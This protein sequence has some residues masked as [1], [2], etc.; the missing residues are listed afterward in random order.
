MFVQQQRLS[1]APV[2][3]VQY[4]ARIREAGLAA[5]LRIGSWVGQD[6]PVPLQAVAKLMPEVMISRRFTNVADGTT[7]GFLLEYCPDAHD[8]AGHFPPHCFP[9][10]GWSPR[11][12]RARDWAVEGLKIEGMEYT[13]SF[14][15]E[16]GE[17]ERTEVVMNCMLRP[18][19]VLRD[20]DALARANLLGGGESV[21]AGQL[22]LYFDPVTPP[23]RR[24]AAA[25]ELIR[26]HMV[27]IRAILAN[28]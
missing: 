12:A 25:T 18:G 20:M 27:L 4:R 15:D 21:G 8:M 6:V 28:P 9:A 13:F 22:Q 24:D 19:A 16:R 26:G 1:R 23:E 10:N 2:G 7:M 3:E 5:P 11:S 17:G 14:A